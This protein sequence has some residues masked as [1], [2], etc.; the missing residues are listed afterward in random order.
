M[1]KLPIFSRFF[2]KIIALNTLSGRYGNGIQSQ[3]DTSSHFLILLEVWSQ[4]S[5]IFYDITRLSPSP[6]WWPQSP[7]CLHCCDSL[8]LLPQNQP[9]PLGLTLFSC[10][11]RLPP[12]GCCS[13]IPLLFLILIISSMGLRTII[14]LR[15]TNQRNYSVSSVLCQIQGLDSLSSIVFRGY[16]SLMRFLI[17]TEL[18][19]PGS[20]IKILQP[21]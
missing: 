15:D 17:L 13:T 9:P 1:I 12:A 3:R 8:T 5:Y 14:R 4:Q 21:F 19:L 18:I 7:L 2:C 11:V 10:R 16:H 6:F 20:L